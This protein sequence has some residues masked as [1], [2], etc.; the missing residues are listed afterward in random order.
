MKKVK[1]LIDRKKFDA[2][3]AERSLNYQDFCDNIRIDRTY[4]SQFVNGH[5]YVSERMLKLILE[6]LNVSYDDLFTKKEIDY[7]NRHKKIQE[8]TLT[9]EDIENLLNKNTKEVSITHDKKEFKF[10][11]KVVG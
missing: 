8:L 4:I 3:L 5:R 11:L 1:T 9:K 7:V 2:L 6:E 10:K